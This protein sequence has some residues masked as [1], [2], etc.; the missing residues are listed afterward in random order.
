M[1]WINQRE[2]CFFGEATLRHRDTLRHWAHEV[3]QRQG[4]LRRAEVQ[5]AKPSQESNSCSL[6]KQI[7]SNC[8]ECQAS[9][10]RVYIQHGV[11][12]RYCNTLY[13]HVTCT[14]KQDNSTG[15]CLSRNYHYEFVLWS[16]LVVVGV[17]SGAF[18]TDIYQLESI[19]LDFSGSITV[20][21]SCVPFLFFFF[22]PDVSNAL[23][24]SFWRWAEMR[25]RRMD[26]WISDAPIRQV[27][28]SS[29]LTE[30]GA[31]RKVPN[32]IQFPLC[33]SDGEVHVSPLRQMQH[34]SNGFFSI[35]LKCQSFFFAELPHREVLTAAQ[36]WADA[37]FR[38]SPVSPKLS[39]ALTFSVAVN[40]TESLNTIATGDNSKKLRLWSSAHRRLSWDRVKNRSNH[41][42]PGTRCSWVRW[43]VRRLA[44]N[45][46]IH[47]NDAQNMALNISS[48]LS[49]TF[50]QS[51]RNLV[52]LDVFGQMSLEL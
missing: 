47:Q 5:M 48:W 38:P 6:D 30:A 2:E 27:P 1:N 43:A 22:F 49:T 44:S 4:A 12:V 39:E 10:F 15:F 24:F 3:T 25:Q 50:F 31:V 37:S 13:T 18:W 21:F 7:V 23:L 11:K 46:S 28:S 20:I 19:L 32:K 41:R 34:F 9:K 40:I 26:G 45:L 51:C 8:I 35:H 52:M 36:M 29:K 42:P 16:F 14:C 33:L 17:G